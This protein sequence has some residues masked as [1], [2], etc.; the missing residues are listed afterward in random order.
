MGFF[1]F[2]NPPAANIAP[3]QV[4]NY[5]PGG[6]AQADSGVLGGIGN[7]SQYNM[8]P[9]LI[10]Q[11]QQITN[12]TV[13][14]PYGASFMTG[15]Q[16]ASGMGQN[17]ATNAYGQ[18]NNMFGMAGSIANTAFDPQSALYARTAQQLQDQTRAGQAA[19]GIA[20]TPYGAGL[21]D[22]AMRNFNIDWQ[23]QQLQRQI[24][25]GQAAGG[26]TA[27][28]V[29]MQSAAP[30]QYY[31]ASGYPYQTSQGMNQ[32]GLGALST[33][34]GFGTSA[35]QIPQ[36]QIQDYQNYLGWG[37]GQQNAN[38]QGNI[39][40]FNSQLNQANSAFGQQSQMMGQIGQAAGAVLP[41]MLSDERLKEDIVPVGKL[42]D[43]ILNVYSY[44]YKGDP[45]PRIGL[46]AQEVERVRPD[47]VVEF[48]GVK[49]V[50]YGKAT[51]FARGIAN[52][53]AWG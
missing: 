41:F 17:A 24:Q 31:T 53:S 16:T 13:N 1:D 10:P 4:S 50:D 45:T 29:G 35:A 15:A 11:A 51:E 27:Q 40:G 23:N 44:R 20:T 39:N 19:R 34:G 43:G 32:A 12:N 9:S 22:Q 36:Q 18:G 30:G 8:W 42:N 7:L 25:G 37:T 3:P 14:N 28:G 5:Q 52:L 46:M 49:A 48:G 38:N 33:L 6:Q 2:L 21:E 26:L 47:A